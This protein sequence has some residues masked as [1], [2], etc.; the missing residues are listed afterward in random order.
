MALGVLALGVV[1]VV[2]GATLTDDYILTNS[3]N[4]TL[5][6]P[7]LVADGGTQNSSGYSFGPNQGLNL[8]SVLSDA[9]NYSI[10]MDFSFSTLN[11]YRK[12][13][14]FKDRSSDNGLYNLT[15]HLNFYPVITGPDASFSPDVLVRVVLT[16]DSSTM[17]TAGYVNGTPEL[18]FTDSLALAVF[19]AP[20]DLI[21]FF[22]DDFVTSQNE[23]SG[24]LATRIQIYQGALTAAEVAALGGPSG[25]SVPE[26]TLFVLTGAGLLGIAFVR[27]RFSVR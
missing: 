6:G 13:L 7:A 11:G 17:T 12:I 1:S 24:G 20:N 2:S 16:R 5:A 18:A 25:S 8:S 21:R 15:Q 23:A 27:K 10:V 14:D 22:E 3:L 4:D 26:P 9:G 19:S